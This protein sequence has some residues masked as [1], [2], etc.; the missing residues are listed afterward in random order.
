[1]H[2]GCSFRLVRLWREKQHN[3]MVDRRKQ[4][5]GMWEQVPEARPIDQAGVLT[6]GLEETPSPHPGAGTELEYG[7]KMP[8]YGNGGFL[9]SQK[10]ERGWKTVSVQ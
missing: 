3:W 2:A 6:P 1:M 7:K 9:K 4:P 10:A 5:G 8:G